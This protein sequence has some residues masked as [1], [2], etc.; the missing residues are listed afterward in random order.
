MD[1]YT[2][3]LLQLGLKAMIGKGR[4]SPEVRD[5]LI[6][7]KAVYLAAVGGA[8]ALLARHILESKVIAYPDLGPEAILELKVEA[9]PC[10]VINDV[11]GGDAYET[12][13]MRKT[14]SSE[15]QPRLTA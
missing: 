15:G 11:Y 6:R 14:Q 2:P 7:H 13:R 5:A 1:S 3:A 10:V 12:A 4:R 9:F 8:G